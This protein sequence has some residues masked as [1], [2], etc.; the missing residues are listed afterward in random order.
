MSASADLAAE[1][2]VIDH[3]YRCLGEMR[4]RTAGLDPV[5]G[6]WVSEKYLQ[7]T[8]ARRLASLADSGRPLCFGRIDEVAGPDG[9]AATWYIGR[10][11][12]EDSR[13]EPV[14]VEWRAPVA[15]AYYR[16][17]PLDPQGLS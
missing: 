8:L 17:S 2:A 3:A 6:D 15:A 14:V 5:A 7:M 16:A 11:H 9:R 4:E 10:R 13:G 1:Q 12:V